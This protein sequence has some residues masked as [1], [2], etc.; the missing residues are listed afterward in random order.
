MGAG[1][2]LIAG[3]G[4]LWLLVNPLVSPSGAHCGA[5]LL[6]VA[7]FASPPV[8]AAPTCSAAMRQAVGWGVT[9][10]VLAPV[11]VLTTRGRRGSR[12]G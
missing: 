1:I 5:P 2:A 6:V 12:H 11:V 10:G 7:E 4:S 9:A 3:F 8:P